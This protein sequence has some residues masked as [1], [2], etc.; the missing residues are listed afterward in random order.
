MI[1]YRLDD[2]GWYQFEWLIQSLLKAELGLAVES[3]GGHKDYGRDAFTASRLRFPD[4][5]SLSDGPFVFQVKF[6]ENAN[7]AGAKNESALLGAVSKEGERILQRPRLISQKDILHYT[8]I[9][10]ALLSPGVRD[11][12]HQKISK[13]LPT[14]EI[15]ILGGGDIC[16]L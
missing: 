10:N 8:L 11:S 9:T 6:V 14:A 12:I 13:T 4:N 3:W 7:A 15:H 1:R 16:D 5:H 2:L